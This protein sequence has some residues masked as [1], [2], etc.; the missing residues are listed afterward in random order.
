LFSAAFVSWGLI[1]GALAFVLVGLVFA[2]AVWWGMPE[3]EVRVLAFFSLVLAIVS[4]IFVNRSFSAS[5][6]TAFRRSNPA[7]VQVLF[8][9]ATL[10]GV[11]LLWPRASELF[12]F[13]PLHPDD[14]ALT[15]GS[16]FVVLAL[17]EIL[18]S[19]W[20]KAMLA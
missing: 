14:L 16:S 12:R 9:V 20:R 11:T 17:L 1:Q 19:I 10:L 4:L 13:G 15:F 8:A 3:S 7:L 18:K 2:W 5:L 6:I